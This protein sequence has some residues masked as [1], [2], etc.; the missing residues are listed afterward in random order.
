[1]TV[2]QLHGSMAFRVL[3]WCH[4]MPASIKEDKLLSPDDHLIWCP[5]VD[6]GPRNFIT[7]CGVRFPFVIARQ[8]VV[9]KMKCL[10]EC[11]SCSFATLLTCAL[12]IHMLPQNRK[13]Y[14]NVKDN[15]VFYKTVEK[16]SYMKH[17]AIC[18]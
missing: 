16:S 11:K 2:L 13:T 4:P 6:S 17:L 9:R 12:I 5:K 3:Q 8:I 15:I 18:M 1:M 10:L 14:C 7:S